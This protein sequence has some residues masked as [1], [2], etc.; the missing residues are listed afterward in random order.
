MLT[1]V[2]EVNLAGLG[3]MPNPVFVSMDLSKEEESDLI[4]LLR[5]YKDCFARSYKDMKGVLPE[6]VQHTIPIRDDAKPVQQHPYDMN[7]K[8]EMIVKEEIDKLL[9]VGF[10]YEIEHTE[11]ISPIVIVT[12]KN[13][14]I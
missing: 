13:G 5:E 2:K 6:V 1:K 8:Y 9:N 3:E 12:K 10:I 14:K 4:S 11:W 7:P